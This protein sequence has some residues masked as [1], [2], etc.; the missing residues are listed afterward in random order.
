M[1]GLGW[2]DRQ[3]V[4]HGRVR[5]G[6]SIRAGQLPAPSAPFALVH[7]LHPGDGDG[8]AFLD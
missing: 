2:L 6:Q 7:R 4:D 8:A 5:A 1:P 3:A